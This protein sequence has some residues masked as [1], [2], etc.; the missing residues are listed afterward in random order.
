MQSNDVNSTAAGANYTEEPRAVKP[1]ELKYNS[2]GLIPAVIQD[3]RTGAVLMVGY[4]N[5]ESLRRT[6]EGGKVCFW[7]R[8]R[9]VYWVKGESSGNFF[10][11]VELYTDCDVDTLLIKVRVHGKGVACHTGRYSC[12]YNTIAGFG[13]Q[14]SGERFD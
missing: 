2:D 4:M 7:S 9:K 6:I 10:E 13:G 3:A 11:P 12:F 1:E 8:S 14:G 5:R